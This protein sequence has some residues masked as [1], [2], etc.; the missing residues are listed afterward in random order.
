M[1]YTGKIVRARA[2]IIQMHRQAKRILNISSRE[3]GEALMSKILI[4]LGLVLTTAAVIVD[5]NREGS[6]LRQLFK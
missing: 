5:L 3:R 6:L 1:R 2:Q 4:L